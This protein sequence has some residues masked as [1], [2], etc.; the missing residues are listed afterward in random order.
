MHLQGGGLVE[1]FPWL[2]FIENPFASAIPEFLTRV[3]ESAG[4]VLAYEGPSSF[5]QAFF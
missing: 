3:S 1:K 2:P 5:E 4:V